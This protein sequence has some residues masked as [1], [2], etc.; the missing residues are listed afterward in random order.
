MVPSQLRDIH[1]LGAIIN[2]TRI[3]FIAAANIGRRDEFEPKEWF[4]EFLASVNIKLVRD[5]SPTYKAVRHLIFQKS[6]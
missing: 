1:W 2:S 4:D 5:G 6:N 3:T